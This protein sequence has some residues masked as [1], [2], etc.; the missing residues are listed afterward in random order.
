MRRR[1]KVPSLVVLGGKSLLRQGK[2][3]RMRSFASLRMTDTLPRVDKRK[4]FGGESEEKSGEDKGLR[5]Q[6]RTFKTSG[7]CGWRV[8]SAADEE[9]AEHR[10]ALVQARGP[11]AAQDKQSC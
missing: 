8:G 1:R 3:M 7:W 2:S 4:G 10:R 11:F 9:N 6:E 5:G